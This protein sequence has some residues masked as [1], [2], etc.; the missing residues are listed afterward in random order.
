MYIYSSLNFPEIFTGKSM[1]QKVECSHALS[2]A[3]Q[4]FVPSYIKK[5]NEKCMWANKDLKTL[6]NE[7]KNKEWKR[8]KPEL[9]LMRRLINLI[10]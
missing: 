9:H 7:K 1:E 6:K 4:R 10:C 2:S 8:F 3:V 5:V